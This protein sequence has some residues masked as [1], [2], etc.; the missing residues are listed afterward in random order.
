MNVSQIMS[1][2]VVTCRPEDGLDQAARA[3]WEH[4]IGCLP[5]V[6]TDGRVV[7]MITDRDVCMAAYTQGRPLAEIP[8][9]TAMSRE[10]HSCLESDGLIE[11]EEIMRSHKVRRLPVTNGGGGLV[12][13]L[14]LND[15]ALEAA[16]EQGRRARELSGEE[17]AATLAAVCEHRG[18]AALR[19]AA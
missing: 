17:V 14:S 5:V 15:L 2:N 19:I 4:D 16:R 9:S 13:M 11:A 7:G 10:V 18:S 8:V 6:G 3:M 12:G 1:R